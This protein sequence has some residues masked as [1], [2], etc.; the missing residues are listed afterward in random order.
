MKKTYEIRIPKL[1]RTEVVDSSAK[2]LKPII[3]KGFTNLGCTI[4]SITPVENTTSFFDVV[5]DVDRYRCKI[6]VI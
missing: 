4:K 1:G 5:T 2:T 3:K 6:R